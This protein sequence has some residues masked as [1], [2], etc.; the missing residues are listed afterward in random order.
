[1]KY[2]FFLAALFFFVSAE[3]QPVTDLSLPIKEDPKVT[4]GVLHNGL[5]YYV[6][7]NSKP[8]NRAE[9]ML[10]VK[11][12][13]IDED[14]DQQGLAH[15][16]EHMSFNGTKNFPKNELVNY[17]ESIG[18]EFGPEINAYTNF[19]ETVY[20]LKIPLDTS[21]YLDKGL[22]VLYDWACQ[23]TDA[24]EEIEKERGVIREEWRRG[25]DANFRMQQI[26]LPVFLH[27]SKY[28]ERLPIG[29]I[30]IIEEGSPETLRRFRK[31]W[32]RPDLQ[33][34]IAVGDFD[35]DEIVQKI[36]EKFSQ[37]PAAEN[38]REKKY[39]DI[40]DH[41]ETLISIVTDKEAQY[42]IAYLFYKHP[43]NISKTVGDYRQSILYGL[44]NTMINNRL[45]EKSQQAEPPFIIGQSVF[46]NLFGPKSVYQ[47]VAIC[48]NDKIEEGLKAVL[49]ENERIK[50]YGFTKTELERNKRALI[51]RIEK[52][53]NERDQQGS[54]N[55][56]EEYKR[57]FLLTEE[58][59]PGIEKEYEYY[60]TF[61]PGI[62]LE[63][64]NQLAVNWI[65][66]ENRVIVINAPETEKTKLPGEEELLILLNELE[67][68]DLEQY[69]DFD[70]D[71]PLIINEL[72]GCRI[73]KEIYIEKV[74]AVEWTLGNAAKVIIKKTDFKDDEIL[75]NAWSPGGTSLY[76]AD[77][78]ISAD[79]ASK[80]MELSGVGEFDKITLDKML[81][82]KVLTI[83]PFI[84]EL[85]EGFTG[86]SSINDFEILLQMLYLYFTEP[87]F[88]ETTFR[89]FMSRMAGILQNR[90]LS[91]EA[92]IQDTL[93][94]VLANY[95]KR[96]R[97]MN[98]TLLNEAD[99]ERIKLIGRDRFK[100]ASDFVF[101]F[102]G[103]IDT[104][105]VR[106]LFEKY[107]G[108]IPSME[109]KEAWKNLQI[110][111]PPGIVEKIVKKGQED[112][113]IQYI[114]FHGDFKYSSQ[115]VMLI[116]AM[117]KIL[118]TRLLEVIRE[119]KSSAYS[120]GAKP[121]TSKY[122]D[123]EYTVTIYYGTDPVKRE[124][125]KNAVFSEIKTFFK[126][127]PSKEELNKAKEK[128]MR[129]REVAMKENSYWLNL[130]S[131]TYYLKEGDFSEFGTYNALFDKITLRSV[132]K[133]FKKYF[134]FK[135]Y[136]SV[137][138]VPENSNN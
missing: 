25:R 48:H 88:D 99:F 91:P 98:A 19:D 93:E 119:D 117:G 82:D 5:T 73:V 12:G 83:S 57:N 126:K 74:D 132:K 20:M 2:L 137:A 21:L 102:V 72:P 30:E 80:I 113:C 50:R 60:K 105:T 70:D 120:I 106:P 100:N 130:L 104:A 8:A 115:N 89:S 85:R 108:S 65:T 135:N 118:T 121:S 34:V 66:K 63:E 87:R 11:A 37:I 109:Y 134:N 24:D 138:L 123:E 38:P 76:G 110:N 101:F 75:F 55:F 96:A 47:S 69:E 14:D 3:A 97:P 64:V 71:I 94:T 36:I 62:E 59:F 32:Y 107:I 1:M 54:K 136:I 79:L 26:W 42:S 23:V 9:L 77:D 43:L 125:I 45:A 40:P 68:A 90:A 35:R 28:A 52:L 129:E 49:S 15:F 84:S 61:L 16:V 131:N 122:A 111:P 41:K 127:G 46:S 13:S 4:K 114:V 6:R 95:H 39:F 67:E 22:Q 78:D 128:M 51:S 81:A 31:D 86:N 92:A 133:A 56:A 53:Y 27:N 124:E 29:K 112:K 17:F 58:P 18:M 7:S 116:D 33:A 103:N 10:A 44:Y